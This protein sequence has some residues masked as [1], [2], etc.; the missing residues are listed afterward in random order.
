MLL[1]IGCNVEVIL[2][3]YV[4]LIGYQ[5]KC[6]EERHQRMKKVVGGE[7]RASLY[8]REWILRFSRFNVV[9]GYQ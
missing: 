8:R 7:K 2:I 9:K 6:A 1:T 5:R 4:E 3:K